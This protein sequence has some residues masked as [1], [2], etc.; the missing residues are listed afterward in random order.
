MQKLFYSSGYVLIADDVCTAVLEYAQ[1]LADVGK[2]DL[3]LVPSLSDEGVRGQT[4]LLLG[5]ASQLF[6]S[7]SLDRGVDL[8]DPGSVEEMRRKTSRLRPTVAQY[9]DQPSSARTA[10][11]DDVHGS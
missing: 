7:P 5:P 8:S 11:F 9:S 4:R 6:A 10:E 2:S 1:A 3:V